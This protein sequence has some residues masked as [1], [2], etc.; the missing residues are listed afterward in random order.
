MK[1][2][3]ILAFIGV[4]LLALKP[5]EAG[6]NDWHLSNIGEVREITFNKNKIQFLS[7]LNQIGIIDKFSGKI[8]ARHV[9][10]ET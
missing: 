10:P 1:I 2:L 9:I 4:G 8:D 6:V 3:V 7:N 5:S